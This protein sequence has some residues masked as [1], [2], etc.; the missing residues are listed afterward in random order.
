MRWN[1]KILAGMFA[2][3]PALL[4]SGAARAEPAAAAE[5]AG[6]PV[7]SGC[8][9][10]YPPY[11]FVTGDGHAHGFS[12]ELL[13]ASLRAVGRE[14]E[15]KTAPWA[16][17]KQDLAEGRLQALPLVGRTP[18]RE[19]I[20]DFTFPYLTMHGTLVVRVGTADIRNPADLKGKQVAVLQGDNAEEYLLRADLGAEIV[21]R[22]SF[23][24]ALR[25]LSKGKY[26]AVVIQKLLAFQLMQQAGL[27]NL[28]AVGPKLYAQD[29]CFA[30]RK[31]DGPLLAALNEGLSIA[32]ADGTFREL[33]ATWFADIE[34][35]GRRM[36]RII[37]GGDKDYPPY[38]F[39]DRNG[40]PA[41]FNVDLTRAIARHLGLAVDIQL[42]SWGDIRKGLE[43]GEIDVVQGMFYSVGR[44][45]AFDFSPPSTLVQHVI[46]GRA[47]AP[48]PADLKA[49]AGKSILSDN[50]SSNSSRTLKR[51]PWTSMPH[52]AASF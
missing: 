24:A 32:M 20:Y 11:C 35:A 42:G 34:A 45:Q 18:E 15:F 16:E 14:V 21:P 10:D 22:P 30:T 36:S 38:E 26:D 3:L 31:G 7:L 37:V 51:R 49:L 23:E 33:H 40:Q 43:A 29:F 44:D 19:D 25:E 8:E 2:L 17:I 27:T 50:S 12:V 47:G 48:E 41:G 1:R 5:P 52:V 13:R 28:A 46:V 9:P 6:P 4:A 39:L